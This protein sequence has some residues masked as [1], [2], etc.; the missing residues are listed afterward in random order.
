MTENDIRLFDKEIERLKWLTTYLG[1]E[2]EKYEE[3]LQDTE[4]ARLRAI[5][6][7]QEQENS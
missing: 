3:A 2:L 6:E 4:K 1:V 5:K 7:L